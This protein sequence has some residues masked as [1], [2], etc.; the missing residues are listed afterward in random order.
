M[1]QTSRNQIVKSN[2]N[3]HQIIKNTNTPSKYKPNNQK[4]QQSRNQITKNTKQI[5]TKH[6]LHIILLLYTTCYAGLLEAQDPRRRHAQRDL[7]SF[8]RGIY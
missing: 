2:N 3:K 6:T 4:H 5:E 8:V 1:H 7:T